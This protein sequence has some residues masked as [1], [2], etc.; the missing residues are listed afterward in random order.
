MEYTLL[1]CKQVVRDAFE[2]EK[3]IGTDDI[4]AVVESGSFVFDCGGEMQTVGPLE[5]VN[6]KKGLLYRRHIT[7][8][9]SIY[10]FRYR[11]ENSVFGEGKVVFR[12]RERIRS[13][14]NLL[15]MS[16]RSV[17][18]DDFSCKKTLF[19]DLVNQYRLENTGQLGSELH[20]DKLIAEAIGQIHNQLHKKLNLAELAAQ[21]YLSY[22]QFSRR[23]KAATGATPQEYINALRLNKAKN[24]LADTDL[25]IR[26]IAQSC[27]FGNEYYFSTFFK[28]C[29]H[30]SPTQYRTIVKTTGET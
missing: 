19:A 29:C 21:Y 1:V 10:L 18:T 5:A 9:A 11:A 26:Q 28:K 4:L 15:H 20:G 25:P 7:Q 14:L 17:Q 30:L 2:H 27:G 22:V 16:E 3:Y 24:L 13:T 23:F 12:D 8:Q 6:F